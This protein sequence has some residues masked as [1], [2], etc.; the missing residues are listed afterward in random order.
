MQLSWLETIIY[1]LVSGLTEILPISSQAHQMILL[2]MLGITESNHLFN[3]FVRL[4]ILVALL[5]S[6]GQGLHRCYR[7]HKLYNSVRRRHKKPVNLQSALDFRF[8][9]V[10]FIPMVVGFF[11]YSKTNSW[12]TKPPV[13]SALLILNSVLLFIPAYLPKGNKDSRNMSILDSLLFGMGGVFSILP[14][15][16]RIGACYS[17]AS[18]RGT[19]SQQ[20]IRWSLMMSI[21]VLLILC[22][23]DLFAL[24]TVGVGG[25]GF[26]FILKA[27][28][29]GVAAFFSA[30][31]AMKFVKNIAVQSGLYG[32]AYYSLGAA[33]F[34]FIIYLY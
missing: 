34:A 24:V 20:A 32:F 19:D 10:A 12:A 9:E 29:S 22:G 31:I 17:F 33:L 27:I 30:M 8:L 13:V 7:E 1:G 4:G 23:F 25:E 5:M 16:S 15:V 6:Y 11:L 26:S 3:F 21:P 28:I 18:A 2:N 14:G